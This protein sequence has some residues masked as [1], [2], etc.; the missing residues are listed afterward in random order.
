MNSW[1]WMLAFIGI[2]TR[3]L[4]FNNKFLGY[5]GEAVL[6]FYVLHQTVIISIGFYVVQWDMGVMSKY[7]IIAATSF[8]GIMAIYEL[9][10]RR[11]NVFRF[12]FGMRLKKK[13]G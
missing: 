7:S 9:L 6:P 10:V 3:F 8:I 12:L 11:I 2:A 13:T 4:N 5:A 1:A